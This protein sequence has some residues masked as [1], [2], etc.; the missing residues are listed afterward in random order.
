MR[1]LVIEDQADTAH[2]IAN[3]LFEAGHTATMCADGVAG[4]GH[5]DRHLSPLIPDS[6]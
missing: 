6:K 1:C 2:Y 4:H 5:L 3:G